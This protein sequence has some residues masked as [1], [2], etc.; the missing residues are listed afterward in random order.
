MGVNFLI[1]MDWFEDIRCCWSIWE[2]ELIKWF[3]VNVKFITFFEV[4]DWNMLQNIFYF[5]VSIFINQLS[6]HIF[7]LKFWNVLFEI[8]SFDTFIPLM[9][10]NSSLLKTFRNLTSLQIVQQWNCIKQVGFKKIKLGCKPFSKAQIRRVII[11][12][13]ISAF[14]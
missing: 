10:L 5:I 1:L 3:F 2:F 14:S 9:R 6:L 12:E 13:F 7:F 11:K 8:C 4:L